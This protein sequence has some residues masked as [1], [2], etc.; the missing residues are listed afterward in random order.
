[1]IV[2]NRRLGRRIWIGILLGLVVV[3]DRRRR[4]ILVI[5]GSKKEA[6]GRKNGEGVSEFWWKTQGRSRSDANRIQELLRVIL[7]EGR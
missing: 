3:K 5:D 1:M 6:F 2:E 7:G 4:W